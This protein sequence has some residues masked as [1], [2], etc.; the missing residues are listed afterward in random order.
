MAAGYLR[1]GS[2]VNEFPTSW[3][4]SIHLQYSKGL[5]RPKYLKNKEAVPKMKTN[6]SVEKNIRSLFSELHKEIL[7]F[8]Q[9]SSY[10]SHI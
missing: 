7:Y 8:T 1:R 4:K 10:G 2:R 6:I 9:L 3:N 5:Q